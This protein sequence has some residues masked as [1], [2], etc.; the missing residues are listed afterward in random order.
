MKKKFWTTFFISLVCFSILFAGL[1]MYLSNKETAI[2]TGEEDEVEKSLDNEDEILVLIMGIDDNDG[3]GGVK[4]VKEKK[5]KGEDRHKPTG[6]RT[7][8]MILGKYNFKTGEVTLLSIPRDTL[9]YIRGRKNLERI[10]HAHSYGGP[11]LSIKTVRDLLNIDLKY[12]VT[13]DYL[14]VKEIVDAIGGVKIDVPVK[15]RHSDP[16]IHLDPGL[17]TLNGEESLMYLRFRSYPD[18]DLGRIKAQQIFVKEFMKQ[19]LKPKNL[20]LLPKLAKTY[21]DYVDTNVPFE[22][23]MKGVMSARKINLDNIKL[24][25]LPG[26]PEY[27]GTTS[28]FIYDEVETKILIEEMFGDYLLN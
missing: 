11:Y 19:L 3:L 23:V 5:I 8:T 9:V 27:I 12:Y 20:L 17:Q 14:A 16:Y 21:Y 15:M 7:D 4:A 2:S 26:K 18:G 22:I 25:T 6:M 24:T 28:Y 13:V 1:G 10:N